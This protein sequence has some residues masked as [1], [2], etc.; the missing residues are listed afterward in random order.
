MVFSYQSKWPLLFIIVSYIFLPHADA[1]QTRR[2]IEGARGLRSAT[3]WLLA[4]G[5]PFFIVHVYRTHVLVSCRLSASAALATVAHEYIPHA[6]RKYVDSD[7]IMF[8]DDYVEPRPVIAGYPHMAH[9]DYVEAIVQNR[10]VQR[11]SSIASQTPVNFDPPRS[12]A[13]S[14]PGNPIAYNGPG[15]NEIPYNPN[16]PYFNARPQVLLHDALTTGGVIPYDPKAPYFIAGLQ[17]GLTRIYYPI[18]SINLLHNAPQAV[19]D[20]RFF[21]TNANVPPTSNASFPKTIDMLKTTP[22]DHLCPNS[23]WFLS[24]QG[25]L[26]KLSGQVEAT[27][28]KKR[29]RTCQ[30]TGIGMGRMTSL[31]AWRKRR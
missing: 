23:P 31:G 3:P 27:R 24:L 17:D 8:E 18:I 28:R 15:V 22:F 19:V 9:R 1:P 25:R 12:G 6:P 10:H 11:N 2:F 16:E 26:S 20:D 29:R 5:K 14:I 13:A 4:L 30:Y 21:R 7:V